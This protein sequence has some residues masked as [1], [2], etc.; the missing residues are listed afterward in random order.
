MNTERASATPIGKMAKWGLTTFDSSR[1]CYGYQ[2]KEYAKEILRLIPNNKRDSV[3]SDSPTWLMLTDR[4]SNYKYLETP[5]LF[6]KMS[7]QIYQEMTTWLS[8][9]KREYIVLEK[10]DDYY[11]GETVAKHYRIIGENE[12]FTLYQTTR[13]QKLNATQ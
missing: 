5:G 4:L 1:V 7:D 9:G 12:K 6:M 13:P 11:I 10:R 3:Y 8:T 2:T